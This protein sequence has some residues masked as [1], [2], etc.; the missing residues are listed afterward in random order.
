MDKEKGNNM[1]KTL[2]ALALSGMTLIGGTTSSY[3]AT[4]TGNI[5]INGTISES[6]CDI[7]FS[8]A[9]NVTMPT[10]DSKELSGSVGKTSSIESAAIQLTGC[11]TSVK[12]VSVTVSGDADLNNPELLANPAA[13]GSAVGVGIEFVGINGKVIPL[14]TESDVL[15]LNNG[16]ASFPLGVRYKSTLDTVVGGQVASTAQ[17]NVNYN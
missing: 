10:I 3:A 2:L 12:G 11:P 1:N 15:S 9:E 5:A 7:D 8:G 13:S 14:G 17:L 16:E 4:A 6:Q